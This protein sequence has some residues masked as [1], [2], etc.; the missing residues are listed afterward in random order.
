M[1]NLTITLAEMK[2]YLR[3]NGF[4]D[5]PTEEDSL[6]QDL[7]DSAIEDVGDYVNRDYKDELG[8][9]LPIPSKLKISAM[10]IV[11]I[12]YENRTESTKELVQNELLEIAGY[13]RSPGL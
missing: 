8:V 12:K 7:I 13:R 5:F 9:Q 4:E 1:L 10:K 6:I 2:N 11:A 3:M